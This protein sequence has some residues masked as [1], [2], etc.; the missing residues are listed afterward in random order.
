[1]ILADSLRRRVL[2]GGL[3]LV[4]GALLHV[5]LLQPVY[6]GLRADADSDTRT[7]RQLRLTEQKSR[8]IAPY[9]GWSGV[10]SQRLID[11][12]QQGK[13]EEIASVIYAVAETHAITGIK[14]A[15]T[16]QNAL[17][18]TVTGAGGSAGSEAP[19]N[20]Y[21]TEITLTFD[22]FLDGRALEFVS[23]LQNAIGDL[24]VVTHLSITRNP[25]ASPAAAND[26]LRRGEP[27]QLLQGELTFLWYD[28]V[29]AEEKQ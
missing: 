17:N 14:Y 28:F 13:W 25:E 9:L 2:R 6:E 20:V 27:V 12:G 29:C 7:L 10:D 16:P 11:C 15:V 24:I 18:M 8:V 3:F 26:A 1:M 21:P 23:D 4:L 5:L 22:T 19:L